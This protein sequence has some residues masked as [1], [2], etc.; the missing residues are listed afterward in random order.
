[1]YTTC[2]KCALP[3]AVTAADLRAGQ[4][5][6]RCGRCANV[7]NALLGL[8]EE[9]V[10]PWPG[11]HRSGDP[12]ETEME[13][14]SAT[15][16]RPALPDPALTDPA[17]EDSNIPAP[18]APRE[19]P[20][21]QDSDPDLEDPVFL[22]PE[23]TSPKIGIAPLPRPPQ[24][25]AASVPPPP[26]APPAPPAPA[27]GSAPWPPS[28]PALRLVD[29]P[30]RPPPPALEIDEPYEESGIEEFR[31]TST[32]ETIVLEGDTFLQTEEAI[33][34]EVL[35]SEIANVSRRLAEARGSTARAPIDE[36]WVD[37]EQD[38]SPELAALREATGEFR[39]EANL[40]LVA[41]DPGKGFQVKRARVDWRLSAAAV[42]LA[43]LFI[44]QAVNH[45]RDDIA[46]HA[47]WF[48][49][50]RSLSAMFGEPLRPNWDLSAYD[51]R[52]LGAA[53]DSPDNHTLRVR[54]SLA[55]VG[56]R[57][58]AMPLIRLTLLD[59]FGKA[60]SRGE[61]EPE[62]Y[63]PQD[64]R[65]QVMIR[66]DQRIDTEVRVLDPSRQASSFELDV[67]VLAAGGGLRCAGDTPAVAGQ[68]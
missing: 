31:G 9:S 29:T 26:P 12:H 23:I 14:A 51:V 2:P 36:P 22:D 35:A 1:M 27:A 10:S 62:Q 25:A 28:A 64:A 61:L 63:L 44:L 59:R 21:F 60:V 8:S 15:M 56:S 18:S 30:P 4:G 38:T 24:R 6:V 20:K 50:M 46:T 40:G 66:R 5:Y 39:H 48:G 34:D 7:F 41:E 58:Q 32:F 37:P 13:R 16:S 45:W 19:F 68:S 17:R 54:L 52:Q 65:G 43:L 33:P 11:A 3:L 47:G 57:S 42:A 55:N 53:A 49:P 67:C